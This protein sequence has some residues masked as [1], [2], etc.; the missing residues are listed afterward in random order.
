MI[1]INTKRQL[2]DNKIKIRKKG[3]SYEA[4]KTIDLSKIYGFEVKKR[5]S[6]TALTEEEAIALIKLREQEEILNAAEQVKTNGITNKLE[7]DELHKA[8]S[9]VGKDFSLKIFVYKML[10]E[11]KL[12]SEIN[13]YSRRRKVSPK[14]VTSYLGTANRQILPIW[15]DLDIRNI[16]TELLQKHF[17]TLDYSEKYLKDIKLILRLTFQTAINLGVIKENPATKIYVGNRKCN[18]GVEIEHLDKERQAVWLDLFE[19][20]GRQWAYLF[21]AILLSGGRPEEVCA[22]SWN[23]VDFDRD[24]I[25]IRKAYKD[26]IVYDNNLKK[27]CHKRGLGDLKTPQSERDIPLHPRLKKLLLKIKTDRILEYKHKGKKWNENDFIFLNEN[28]EPFVSE[29]LTNKMPKFIKKYNLEHMTVYALRHSYAS[30][31]SAEGMPPEVLHILMGHSDFDTTR[32]YYIH[33]TEARKQQ[34]ALKLYNKQYSPEELNDLLDRNK[35]YMQ[36][37]NMLSEP[38]LVA[39]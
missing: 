37:I 33:I 13:L 6:K 31:S 12:Q 1:K 23:S 22:F 14:T 26:S 38:M 2:K 15:G 9:N 11:K 3:N 27:K 36:K 17:D 32:R 29:M 34:E 7:Y 21:E 28:G 18:K 4:R 39:K 20:D 30:L 25:Y 5:I 19:Q 35:E 16:T 24:M 10:Q 8:M